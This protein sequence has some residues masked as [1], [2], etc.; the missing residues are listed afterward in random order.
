M[1]FG[2]MPAPNK[3]RRERVVISMYDTAVAALPCPRECSSYESTSN[4]KPD[5]RDH[6]IDRARSLTE[7]GFQP[8]IAL[9]LQREPLRCPHHR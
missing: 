8:P 4:G 2:C 1:I 6:R 9:H 7:P 3:V 5:R